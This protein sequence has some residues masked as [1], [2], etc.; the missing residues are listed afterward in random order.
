M[1]T[2]ELN[3]TRRI[4]CEFEMTVPLVGKG[5]VSDVQEVLAEVLGKNGICATFRPYDNSLVPNGVDVAVEYDS[6]ILGETKFEGIE[7]FPIEVKTRIL[8]GIDDWEKVVSKT[9]EICRY[10]GAR[11]NT[12]TGFHLHID[13]PDVHNRPTIIKSLFNLF[14]RFEPLIYG[15]IA[16]SRSNNDYA[17][18]IPTEQSGLFRGCRSVRSFR[19]A[20]MGWHEKSGLNLT[21]LFSGRSFVSSPRIEVRYHQGT[22]DPLKAM[23]WT[24]FC[25]QMVQHAIKRNC[26]SFPKQVP[27]T[28]KGL[29]NLLIS[30]GF[31]PNNNVYSKVCP[32][33]RD[34]GKYLIQRWKQFNGNIP[35]KSRK[36]PTG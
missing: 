19:R 29:E 14:F 27:N 13:L 9:L 10:M 6:S 4:G 25:L 17:K 35:L 23:Q 31:K 28:R 30:V 12:S 2:A 15:L 32:E 5:C 21:H 36:V 7:W 3:R 33:L 34:T 1:L 11:V 22:L 20:L 8:Q 16:P 18:A 24:R 26:Q